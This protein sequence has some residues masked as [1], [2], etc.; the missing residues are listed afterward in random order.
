MVKTQKEKKVIE[1]YVC[2]LEIFLCYVNGFVFAECAQDKN[3]YFFLDV[4]SVYR[5][6][7][8]A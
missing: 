4:N 3:N 8:A 7:T 2:D 6:F 1:V 5:T